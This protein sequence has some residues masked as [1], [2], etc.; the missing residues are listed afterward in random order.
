MSE[1]TGSEGIVIDNGS[2]IIK[3]GFAGQDAPGAVFPSIVGKPKVMSTHT[4]GKTVY[5]GNEAQA[6]CSILH[7]EHPIERRGN[8]VSWD[9]MEKIWD[10]TFD[11][12]LRVCTEEIRKVLLTEPP[13]NPKEDREK[14]TELM[15]EKYSVPS[16]YLS[17]Q[18][19]LGLYA[20]GRTSGL[21]LDS[22]YGRCHRYSAGLRRLHLAARRPAHG[23]GWKGPD[24]V[25]EKA[26][27]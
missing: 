25:H 7:V 6:K 13:L 15:F 16:M 8:V 2:G 1:E 14:M 20:S 11:N 12:E 10:H 21:V 26:S 9:G 3:A 24:T 18:A 19:T 27:T 4:G 5:V 22:G 23:P 17:V